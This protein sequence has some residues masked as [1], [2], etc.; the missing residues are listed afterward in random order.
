LVAS[1]RRFVSDAAHELRSPLTALRGEIE[2][3]LR[4]PRDADAYREALALALERTMELSALVDD[5]LALARA[6]ARS[7]EH[8]RAAVAAAIDRAS[9]LVRPQGEP[10]G[11]RVDVVGTADVD[12][13]IAQRDLERVVR[14]L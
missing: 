12:A 9:S 2:L 7:N 11:V 13:A 14:N 5:L 1:H 4:R 8:P 10:R 6:R 3:S